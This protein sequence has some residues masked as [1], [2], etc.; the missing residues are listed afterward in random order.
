M[1]RPYE[2]WYGDSEPLALP[3]EH[4]TALEQIYKANPNNAERFRTYATAHGR[5]PAP[6]ATT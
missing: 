5:K 3:A 1:N 2:D 4:S 6:P